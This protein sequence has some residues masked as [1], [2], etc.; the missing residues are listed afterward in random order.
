MTLKPGEI[1][2]QRYR[3]IKQLGQG[4]FGA[5]YR[6]E[7]LSLKTPCALKENL[8]YWDEAQR[9]FARE[10]HIL[11]GLRHPNLPRVID[12]FILPGQGQYLVMD[13]VEGSD[14]Q[15]VIDST[16]KPLFE[17]HALRII[18]QI[19]EAL[20]YLHGQR[21]AVVHRDIK[22]AN[23][24]L[25]PTG[26]AMLVDFGVAKFYTPHVQTT[27]GAR[28]V[29]PGY[30]PIEQYGQGSTDSRAD[31]Y[32][33]GATLYTLLTGVRPVES[34]ERATGA[35]LPPPRRLNPEISV[36][37]EN[38]VLRAMAQ[39]AANRYQG[40]A[41][42]R[43]ALQSAAV[44]SSAVSRRLPA[45]PL[46]GA[47]P[48][49]G[50]LPVG[51]AQAGRPL[52]AAGA[53]GGPLSAPRPERRQEQLPLSTPVSRPVITKPVPPSYKT[54]VRMEYVE[55]PAGEFL[56]GTEKQ[57][58][59]LPAFKIGRFPVTNQQYKLFLLSNPQ[60]AAPLGW[61]ERDFPVSKARHP[62]AGVSYHEALAFCRWIGGRLPVVDEWEK[63][64]RGVDGRAYPWGA[65]W[66]NGR[67]CNNW[68]AHI[69]ATTPVDRY[70]EGASPYGAL[71]MVG[72]VWEWTASE[73][74]SPLLH[75]VRGGSYK[76]FSPLGVLVTQ[77]NYL[78]L[79]DRREDTGFRCAL[80]V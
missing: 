24:R 41:E 47:A 16:R 66:L 46:P 42:L 43:A 25:T 40:I 10:A 58:I 80:S 17:R 32:A 27:I 48:G 7:D 73:Y 18:D 4:G 6:A 1:I 39:L 76:S 35:E 56:F 65:D 23:I 26:S 2:H 34:I 71:D 61:K 37:V 68:D 31:I 19:C 60:V 64:A 38:A 15:Q 77:H 63:A 12:Y 72:N 20:A 67:Y 59:E 28:A 13:F 45:A 29:T 50:G 9:Q 62:V 49:T 75:V 36:E 57:R 52:A 11:A 3:V 74:Q 53:A 55:V 22:P 51:G 30:S 14:L 79:D 44:F 8:D 78:T 70:P 21:P 69:D 33:L 54:S 5:V